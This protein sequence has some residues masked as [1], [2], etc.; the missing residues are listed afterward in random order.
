[1]V[2][3]SKGII[4]YKGES[5]V[6]LPFISSSWKQPVSSFLCIVSEIIYTD[7]CIYVYILINP[8]F[9]T[10]SILKNYTFF[11]ILF[12][13]LNPKSVNTSPFFLYRC[14]VWIY[15][16]LFNWFYWHCSV[17]FGFMYMAYIWTYLSDKFLEME[18]PSQRVI[19][20]YNFDWYC[21]LSLLRHSYPQYKNAGFLIPALAHISTDFGLF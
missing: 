7:I 18:L 4:A 20:I 19:Y 16:N 12:S 5:P 11:G 8:L 6:V 3:N 15:H 17:I 14:I 21:Q 13:S 1:M 9:N 10:N 2:W